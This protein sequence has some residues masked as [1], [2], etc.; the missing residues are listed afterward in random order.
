MLR[1]ILYISFEGIAIY[2][3]CKVI[4]KLDSKYPS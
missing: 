3:W 2:I 4:Q 1:Y